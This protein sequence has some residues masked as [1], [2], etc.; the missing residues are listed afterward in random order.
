MKF[1]EIYKQNQESVKRSLTS[2]WCSEAESDMQKKYAEQLKNIIDTEIF[3]SEDYMPLV[4]SME[5]YQSS[6][7]EEADEIFNNIDENLWKKCIGD[8]DF[9]P[10][11]HQLEAWKSLT[12][13]SCRSMVVTTGT[14]SGKTECFMIPLVNNLKNHSQQ[15]G[16]R[17][18]KAI[19]LYPLNALMED[20]KSRLNNFLKGTGLTFAVYNGNLEE[21]RD[22]DNKVKLDKEH[23]EFETA[24]LTRQ[25]LHRNGADIILTNPTMLEYMLIRDKDQKLLTPGTLRWIVVDEAHTFTGAAAAELALLIR[26][27]NQAFATDLNQLHFAASS[28]TIG[29]SDDKAKQDQQLKEFISDISH[30]DIN[31]IDVIKGDRV[32]FMRTDDSEFGLCK[33]KLTSTDCD[34]IRLDELINGNSILERLEKLDEF[35]DQGLRAKV[36]FFYRA[37]NS[38]IR[39]QLDKWEDQQNGVLKLQ[40]RIPTDPKETPALEWVRCSHC[41]EYMAIAK[42]N[43][44]EPDHY[45]AS[46]Q[47]DNDMFDLGQVDDHSQYLFAVI[48]TSK[49]ASPTSNNVYVNIKG[50]TFTTGANPVGR[51]ALV[52]NTD[53]KCPHCDAELK[54][55]KD[56]ENED[57]LADT[58]IRRL[59]VSADN[60]SRMV[61][62]SLLDCLRKN[63][64]RDIPH[65]GQQYLSFVDS[66]QTAAQSTFKQNVEVEKQW[67]YSRVYHELLQIDAN[68]M[69]VQQ[70]SKLEQKKLELE[71]ANNYGAEYGPICQQIN[72]LRAQNPNTAS[73]DYLEW[74]DIYKLL[75]EQP[76]CDYICQQFCNR[77]KGQEINDDD[78][79]NNIVRQRYIYG[80]MVSNFSTYPP[81]KES[82]ETMGLMRSY[83]PKLENLTEVP[84]AVKEFNVKFNVN[85]TLEEWQNLLQIFLDRQLRGNEMFYMEMPNNT[86][87]DIF[88]CTERFGLKRPPHRPVHKPILLK[89]CKNAR[90]IHRL[91]A[92]LI[93]PN[94]SDLTSVIKQN[95][96]DINKVMEALWKDLRDNKLI[97]PSR[98]IK[99][100]AKS[101]NINDTF[102]W[103]E[104]KDNDEDKK[105]TPEELL[106]P[107]GLQ[108]R[109]N[110]AD[111]AFKLPERVYYCEII[112]RGGMISHIRPSY[113]TFMKYCPYAVGYDI[114]KPIEEEVWSVNLPYIKGVDNGAKVSYDTI[115]AWLQ[116]NRGKM[117]DY[118][119]LGETGCFSN[120]IHS[121]C[122]Y[123]E[124]FI[125]AEHTAQVNKAISK[126]SQ[127]LFKN[128]QL[129]I[130][131]CSTTMEMGVD[132][133]NLEVVMMTS[134]PPHPANY[135]QRAGRSGRNDDSRSVSITLCTSDAV[136]IRVLNDPMETIIKRKVE[137]PF[138]DLNCK[139]I[140][141]R[142]VNAFLYR[143]SGIFFSDDNR[144]SLNWRIINIFSNYVFGPKDI[145]RNGVKC[146]I[147]ES[148]YWTV[149]NMNDNRHPELFPVSDDSLGD[150]HDTR[151]EKFSNWLLNTADPNDLEFL[152]EGTCQQGREG[153]LLQQCQE[154]W[155][156]LYN[157]I[158]A[159]L[160]YYGKEYEA[161]LQEEMNK[162]GGNY[163]ERKLDTSNGK[164]LRIKH[165]NILRQ[166]LIEYLATHRFTPNANMPV[167]IVEFEVTKKNNNYDF[168]LQNPSYPLQQ[169]LTQYA[170]GNTVVL[171]NRV[172][173]VAGVDYLGKD[174]NSTND[175][176]HYFYTDGTNV[177]HSGSRRTISPAQQLPWPVNGNKALGMVRVKKFIPDINA[178]DSRV[179]EPAPYT[180]V[181]AQLVG[182]AD[183]STSIHHLLN[184]RCNEEAGDAK[185]LYYNDGI[186]YGYCLCPNC[187][188]MVLEHGPAIKNI[189]AEMYTPRKDNHDNII[190][191]DDN[192]NPI[193]CKTPIKKFNRNVIIGDLIQT[194][195]CEMRIIKK[196][197]LIA[198]YTNDKKLLVTLGLV[199]CRVFTELIG[200]ERQ[201]VDFTTVLNGN[202]CI[203][204][205]NPGGSGYSNQLDD[206][207]LMAKVIR[208]SK[209]MLDNIKEKEALLDRFTLR[210][211]DNIDIEVAKEWLQAELDSWNTL[212]A[213]FDNTPYTSARWSSFHEVI[214]S[215]KTAAQS[216]ESGTIFINDDYKKWNYEVTSPN[217][218]ESKTW[219]IRMQKISTHF[220]IYQNA[221]LVVPTDAS[222]P[223]P[224]LTMLRNIRWCDKKTSAPLMA[225]G[226]WPL[227]HVRGNIYFTDQRD[228]ASL[229]SD[230]ARGNVYCIDESIV[231]TYTTNL[232]DL[233]Q[234]QSLCN[235]L[236]DSADTL[237]VNSR[238]LPVVVMDLARNKNVDVDGFFDFCRNSP[239]KV[240]I[241]YTDEH[242]KSVT[243]IITTLHFIED[244]LK[245]MGRKDNFHITFINE[246]YY[247]ASYEVTSPF[248]NIEKWERRNTILKSITNDWFSKQYDVEDALS[249]NCWENDTRNSKDLPHWRVLSIKC[250][251]KQMD[252][253]P[254]GGII[255]EWLVDLSAKR[256]TYTMNDTTSIDIPLKRSK[257]IMYNIEIIG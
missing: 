109:L 8:K 239:D 256:Y 14:G 122:S 101:I 152:T 44:N 92:K 3:T 6:T 103:E 113:V 39:V 12:D 188:K 63:P 202:L 90:L 151:Y 146:T 194:D 111:L 191:L 87:V 192:G 170:P 236:I 119:M 31:K 97:N 145:K 221:Q 78:T 233:T 131:A 168:R 223:S 235:F 59:R 38:G 162:V 110:L 130:L 200:K 248:K 149:I 58:K 66:R 16:R 153:V 242:L 121:V 28:A 225:E 94:S 98:R 112:E 33:E 21:C 190:K 229:N 237:K 79:I 34:Y 11:R 253:Y 197:N 116:A 232:L 137:M 117:Y 5:Y 240:E 100:N 247:D 140:I 102:G 250:G 51:W 172:L 49:T 83:Y 195:F 91:V 47:S 207:S 2:M 46:T 226:F 199:F 85:I 80:V 178:Q 203:F 174:A 134:I 193:P 57:N 257:P 72:Q 187:G 118:G 189:P 252:I 201:S 23:E 167:N 222:I 107:N 238:S 220:G 24:V 70:L 53:M 144:S 95:R 15:E 161:A 36:H 184:V 65:H 180:R 148:D 227:A 32:P 196:N 230:W 123:A 64:D 77:A 104:D 13:P 19:F 4:Q 141:Q 88:N 68:K 254:N 154:Q 177:V 205:T 71:A 163:S 35:C 105:N 142:H 218:D 128:Q 181:N 76:E 9:T 138:V 219:K 186:G 255:N 251:N 115:E 7:Q 185:I 114:V 143:H 171:E 56:S 160:N 198:D 129:N 165:N 136:G 246:Q 244:M 176:L 214:D 69:I 228:M 211:L 54:N 73:K 50:G 135:K 18:V 48:D 150:E 127:E 26:R 169:S 155:V 182:A 81:F 43:N 217:E 213:N 166:R 147:P 245:C 158:E 206:S 231:G 84:D 234:H 52:A 139:A 10:Y 62:P 243:G 125:Q 209:D 60:I 99:T 164:R 42:V 74:A 93:A 17:T 241:S 108:Y 96:D 120:M 30:I 157:D 75:S 224:A 183:W 41:G 210:H 159:E 67:A 45:Y 29:N 173:R 133:G 106:D 204:D 89:D 126:K 25:E 175:P 61:A 132:L 37:T 156:E 27:V 124:P 216:G 212:P 86:A 40:T 20:Q 55:K 215:F 82:A 179:I 22:E 249:A 1:A 208:C